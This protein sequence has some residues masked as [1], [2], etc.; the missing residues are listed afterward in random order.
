MWLGDP[1]NPSV[2]PRKEFEF[3]SSKLKDYP[4]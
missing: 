4:P 2:A 3:F 1:L